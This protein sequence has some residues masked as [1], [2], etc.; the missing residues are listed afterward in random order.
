MEKIFPAAL[1]KYLTAY[2]NDVCDFF[3]L[4]RKLIQLIQM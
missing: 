4:S 3:F 2:T 1:D